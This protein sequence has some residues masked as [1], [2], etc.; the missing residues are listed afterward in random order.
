M[1]YNPILIVAGEPN[2]IFL[3]IFFKALKKI[4]VN[5]PMILIASKKLV[6]LQMTKLKFNK[7]IKILEKEKNFN[8]NL[9]NKSINLINVN[10][11]TTKAFENISFKRRFFSNFF[12]SCSFFNHFDFI[13]EKA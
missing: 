9:N 11:N 7:K 13:K 10:Y 12:F 3:E 5:R 2:S 8:V 6:K 1:S 4:K